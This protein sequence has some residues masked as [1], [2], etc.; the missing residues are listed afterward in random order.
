MRARHHRAAA[1]GSRTPPHKRANR[2]RHPK[3]ST[4]RERSACG[5]GGKNCRAR[6]RRHRR[7]SALLFLVRCLR[8]L[9]RRVPEAWGPC[10]PAVRG[11]PN[12]RRRPGEPSDPGA[13]SGIA[14]AALRSEPA[15]PPRPSETGERESSADPRTAR[16]AERGGVAGKRVGAC[17]RGRS[18]VFFSCTQG[19][20][21]RGP[22]V[23]GG[24]RLPSGRVPCADPD[25]DRQHPAVCR[26]LDLARMTV[27][28]K[29]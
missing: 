17:G 29:R 4:E 1:S 19:A 27:C 28:D 3:D 10:G 6:R 24:L 23:R 18:L 21:R 20:G 12:P 9:L 22:G 14:R 5:A 26:Q 11:E 25:A 13:D 2:A 8:L 7:G 15:A 16:T